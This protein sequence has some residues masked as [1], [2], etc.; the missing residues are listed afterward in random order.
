MT[1]YPTDPLP[2]SSLD[3]LK[4]MSG[5][6]IEDSEQRRCEEIWSTADAH[7]LMGMFRWIADDDV[8]FYEFMVIN[9]TDTGAE[10]HVKH[11]HPTLVAWEE[12]Q[13]YQAFVLTALDSTRAVFAAIREDEADKNAGGWLIYEQSDVNHLDVHLVEASGD[14]KLTFHFTRET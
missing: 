5:A 14:V 13:H 7:T 10:L 2:A 1:S 6:W 9:M 3:Q 11:F 12:R 4:W 8:S